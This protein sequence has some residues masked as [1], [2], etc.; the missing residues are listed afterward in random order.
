MTDMTAGITS[1]ELMKIWLDMTPA[2][3]LGRDEEL[4]GAVIY[5]MSD[6]A[7]FTTGSEIVIDGAYTV[8]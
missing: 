5:L 6:A 4:A 2:G 8:L 1:P 3:R 7:S